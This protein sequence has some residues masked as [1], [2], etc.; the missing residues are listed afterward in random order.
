MKC[1][2]RVGRTFWAFTGREGLDSVLCLSSVMKNE[3]WAAVRP[4]LSCLPTHRPGVI[5]FW[6][7]DS[8]TSRYDVDGQPYP[9]PMS[10]FYVV[11]AMRGLIGVHQGYVGT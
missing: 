8:L 3:A 7:Y 1:D 6:P 4:H 2:C 9:M 5:H 10:S 11:W